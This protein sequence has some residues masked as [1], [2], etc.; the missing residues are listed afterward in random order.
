MKVN[1]D[2][3]HLVVVSNG[4]SRS[5]SQSAN[6]VQIETPTE[7]IQ[8]RYT[9]KLLGYWIQGDL[10]WDTYIRD[11]EENLIKSLSQR[12]TAIKRITKLCN[13]KT[14]KMIANGIF[15]S[16]LSYLIAVWS[17]CNKD[18]LKALQVQQDS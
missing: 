2:K 5:K 13:F 3:T 12:I 15:L 9:E 1:D 14:R 11:S 6:L 16:K 8:A 7:I 17:N 10:K 18:L 4:N